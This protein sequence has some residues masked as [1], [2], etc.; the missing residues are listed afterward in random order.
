MVTEAH[1]HEQPVQVSV[2]P[3]HVLCLQYGFSCSWVWLHDALACPV[4]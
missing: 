3:F 2:K 1:I 4:V